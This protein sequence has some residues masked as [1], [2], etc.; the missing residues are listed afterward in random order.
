M[1]W[2]SIEERLPGTKVSAC[3]YYFAD[4]VTEILD[5]N[6]FSPLGIYSHF[7]KTE[8]KVTHWMPLPPP[9][10]KE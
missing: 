3:L 1:E 7:G 2:I 9:P 8:T 4:G 6:Q 10:H 5:S